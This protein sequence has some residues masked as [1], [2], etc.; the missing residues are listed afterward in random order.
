MKKIKV[1]FFNYPFVYK[2]YEA[3]IKPKLIKVLESGSYILQKELHTFEK[4]LAKFLNAKYAIGVADGTNAIILALRAAGIKNGDEVIMSSHTY[5]ATASAVHDC[6]G[7]PVLID[8]KSDF[9]IDE[10][11]I[12][13]A[14]TKKTKFIMPTQL[15]GRVCKMDFILK[16]ARKYNLKVIEDGAQSIGAKYK[17]KFSTTF[18]LA[19]TLSFY[20]AKILGCFGDGGAIITN[21]KSLA[22]KIYKLRDHG[23]GSDGKVKSWGTNSRLDNIQALI[24]DIKLKK[25]KKDLNRRRQIALIYHKNLKKI[26]QLTLPPQPEKNHNNYDVFQNYEI[27]A[28]KRNDLRKYLAKKGIG[29]LVQW[30]G[31]PL[32]SIKGIN[33]K[34]SSIQETASIFKKIMMLPMNPSI[35]NFQINYIVKEIKNF[36]FNR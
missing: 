34:K 35:T 36:Y 14:I 29:T 6:G 21:N 2:Q 16:I 7:V 19:G 15:N 30:N 3:L 32:H 20:P 18:G 10:K 5:I 33:V 22:L 27:M 31:Q 26:K 17:G 9:M 24:L 25:L 12:E 4:N 1:P 11:K 8:C 13:S 23:R 28:E